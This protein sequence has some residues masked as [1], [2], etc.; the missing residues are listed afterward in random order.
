MV[1]I[2][3]HFTG[4]AARINGPDVHVRLVKTIIEAVIDTKSKSEEV[5]GYT[6]FR[7]GY[8]EGTP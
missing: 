2:V 8:A 4:L 7:T 5:P 3:Y 1:Q 6:E